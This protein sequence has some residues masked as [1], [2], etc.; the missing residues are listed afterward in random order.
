MVFN[1]NLK[2][3]L[4][5]IAIPLTVGGI[6]AF[7]V[8][9]YMDIYSKINNPPLS[10]PG[11]LF[12]IVWTVLYI[13]MGVSLYLISNANNQNQEKSTAIL[14]FAI[15]LFL[16]FI[17]SPIFFLMQKFLLAAVVLV[18]MLGFTVAMTLKFYK[19]LKFAAIIQIPYIVWLGFA[20]YLNFAIYLLN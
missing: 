5:S 15:Q 3:F 17:W 10:P 4:I 7:I 19:I 14:F 8:R 18:L 1:F 6:S 9:D 20:G 13:L 11:W 12:P 2:K 16:N